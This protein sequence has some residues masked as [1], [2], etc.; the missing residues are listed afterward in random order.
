MIIILIIILLLLFYGDYYNG[1]YYNSRHQLLNKTWAYINMF[2]KN[3]LWM[4]PCILF[5]DVL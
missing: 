3:W 2:K 5:C 1:V 4:T